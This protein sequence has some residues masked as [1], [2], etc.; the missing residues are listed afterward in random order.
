LF[1]GEI[2]DNRFYLSQ[3]KGQCPKCGGREYLNAVY[4]MPG[5][6]GWRLVVELLCQDCSYRGSITLSKDQVEAMAQE[7][8]RQGDQQAARSEAEDRG[9]SRYDNEGGLMDS[10]PTGD[11]TDL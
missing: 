1:E 4:L 5:V 2:M 3:S 11:P 8:Q 7:L 6:E 9:I 10:E